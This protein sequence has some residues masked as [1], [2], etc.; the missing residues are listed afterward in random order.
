[1][2]LTLEI[3]HVYCSKKNLTYRI[4]VFIRNIMLHLLDFSRKD[5]L[6]WFIE[7]QLSEYVHLFNEAEDVA[8]IDKLDKR[9]AWFKKHLLQIEEKFGAMFPSEWQLSE[10]ITVEFCNITKYVKLFIRNIGA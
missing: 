1:M 3:N 10:R 2:G 6:K 4:F 5:L 7:L 8:W 9:Y